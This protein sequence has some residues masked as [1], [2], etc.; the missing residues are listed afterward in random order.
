MESSGQ[1]RQ[2]HDLDQ[3]DVLLFDMVQ[4]RIRMIHAQRSVLGGKV[5]AEHE[6][7]LK[8][9]V[10]HTSYWGDGVVRNAVGESEDICRLIGIAPPVL[11]H[12]G[13]GVDKLFFIACL[14]S[15]CRR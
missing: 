5:I 9:P 8:E 10:L 3:S 15:S 12:V 6:V 11:Q 13:A 14:L 1:Y 4:G 7:A 2:T